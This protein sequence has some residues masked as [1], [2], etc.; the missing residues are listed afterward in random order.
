MTKVALV[1]DS[2]TLTWYLN[3]ADN[4]L[5]VTNHGKTADYNYRLDKAIEE[6]L[7]RTD[8]EFGMFARGSWT[9]KM[10]LE[11]D[12]T[13]VTGVFGS[14]VTATGHMWD[15][16]K[17]WEPDIVIMSWG[18]NDSIY[19]STTEFAG[20]LQTMFDD[21]VT[22]GIDVV[23]WNGQS[24]QWTSDYNDAAATNK[25]NGTYPYYDKFIE[26]ARGYGFDT[27][28][29]RAA[30][31]AQQD[32]G[33]WD[34]FLHRDGTY[35]ATTTGYPNPPELYYDIHT[36]IAGQDITSAVLAEYLDYGLSDLDIYLG[37]AFDLDIYLGESLQKKLD[38]L[39]MGAGF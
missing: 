18:N 35:I 15:V 28:D 25:R 2:I 23:C 10:A 5:L 27:L 14:P 39:F 20:Y 9:S 4:N 26:V 8:I 1:G 3:A 34:L 38:A 12:S 24:V 37:T 36:W 7:A 17:A 22:L 32:L 6:K 30:M 29:T 21:C 13:Y 16:V 33:N 11:E 19:Y 31:K